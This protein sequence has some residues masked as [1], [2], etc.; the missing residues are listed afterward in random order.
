M[1]FRT[2]YVGKQLTL[3]RLHLL[4]TYNI[5]QLPAL[6]F[7]LDTILLLPIAFL[8]FMQQFM[9]VLEQGYIQ[10]N[11]DVNCVPDVLQGGQT[12]FWS[13]TVGHR[14]PPK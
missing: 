1:P 6:V 11:L 10:I 12:Y 9:L 4:V 2:F 14:Q 8:K 13:I 7:Q 5:N 3:L